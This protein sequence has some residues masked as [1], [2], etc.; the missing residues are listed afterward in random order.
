MAVIV[1]VPTVLKVKL[2][3]ARVPATNVRFP[4]VAPLSSAIVALASEL[5]TVTL[6][7][8]VLTTFQLASTALT[9]IPLAI[10]VPA[11]CAVGVAAVLPVA[12]PGAATSPGNRIC[13]FVTDPA[14]TVTLALV[15][16]VSAATAS[17]AVTV[18]V[19]TVLK[20]KLD[21]V[22][23]PATSVRLPA[24]AP[25]S[26]AL[27]ALLSELV[28]VTSGVALLTTFQFAST[29]LTRTPLAIAVPAVCAVGVAAVLPVAVP[30]AATSP[31]NRICS[32]VTAPAFTV[33]LALVLAA[34]TAAAS[35][36]VIVRV[37]AVLKVKLDKVRVPATSVRL[38][39]VAPLSS[40][41]VALLSVLVIVTLV[42]AVLTTFQLASTALTTIPLAIA[43]PA[44][45]AV[46]AAAVLP[47]VV[48]GA[49]TSPGSRICSFVTAPAL[50][51]TLALVLAVNVPPAS[52][53]VTG[54]VPTV[55]KVKLE[56]ARV[57]ATNI[58]VPGVT[59]L[60]SAIVALASE[61]VIVT[62]VVAVLTTFQLASTALTK[63][64]L[65]IAVPAVCAVGAAAVLP[66]V[67][68]GAATSP[69]S[70][71]CSFVTAPALTVT[72]ALVLAVNVPPA[73]V[74]VTGRVPTVLKVKL[75]SA[76]VPATNVMFPAVA[77]LSS[78]IVALASELAIVTL[79]VAVL[80]TFQLA[81]TALT[82]IPLAIAVPAVCAVGA[83]AVLP[84]A[85]PGAATS[86]GSRICSF[87]TAPAFTVT[88]ALVL[89]VSAATASVAVTVRAPT[90]L[91]VKLDKV[92]VPATSVRL[93]AA[94]PL[95]SVLAALLSELVIVMSGVA[96]L[97]TFQF[98]STALTRTPL[99]IA[100]P[101]VCAVG[102]AAVLPVAV[103]GAATSPGNRICSFVTAPAFT[104]TLALVLAARTAAASV[105][106]IVRVAAVLK[107][108]LDKVRVPATSVR[109][110]AVTPLSSAIVALLSELP[111]V[112]LGVAVLT[113]FQL[114]ST[115]LTTIPLAIAVPAVCA[116]GAAAVLPVAVPGAATSP[117]N[118][119]CSFVTAP[120]FTVTLAL[121]LAVNVLPA[122]V[123]VT[124]RVP[125]VLK[126]K[127]ESARVPATNVM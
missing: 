39:A 74:A 83:A 108:K 50:T 18:R 46:G 120:A 110:P 56:S 36:A 79:V 90:V 33:T 63:I 96:V 85:V 6:V 124:V 66:V 109:L 84:V 123:A 78:A 59:P 68:P 48:P 22:P 97:T 88:L 81:S 115:A 9:T 10:A 113:T 104:V 23:V 53:A 16:A 41:I 72:L 121:V 89:A 43:V 49:A 101:A 127:L 32:F 75:E 20:V 38:P 82:T 52:V 95:S 114:A 106:V 58:R 62:L 21:E 125:A 112:T 107:V 61:L 3:S 118:K 77:P 99:A 65:A 55:L 70:R 103:P 94:A 116:V 35:V 126:V 100:V 102:V 69:G 67:V 42:V 91:K 26:S 71:I 92:P 31:G 13:S 117:G 47:V 76:R 111:I 4:A 19:P 105:A 51:V 44:V 30:G 24:A 14:F 37:A 5:V 45:C 54:R 17:V 122:S 64:P 40:A 86:P 29:A 7:V 11:V 80:T 93:P 119:I 57:P 98:A 28:I 2:E 8:A 15:L 25:L 87:V 73:S 60:S 27:A 1:C 34:R 12:V